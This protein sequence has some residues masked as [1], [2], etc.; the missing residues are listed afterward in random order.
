MR[1][2][3]D[4]G[5]LGVRIDPLAHENKAYVCKAQF[6]VDCEGIFQAAAYAARVVAEN[7]IEGS[8]L[9]V[10]S[11]QHPAQPKTVICGAG[12]CFIAVDVGIEN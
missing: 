2:E 9:T 12:N 4:F 10:G 7:D 1:R 3:Q 8:F 6:I 5:L 11:G